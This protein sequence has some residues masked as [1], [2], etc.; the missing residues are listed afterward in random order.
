MLDKDYNGRGIGSAA[1]AFAVD[2]ARDEL[3]LHTDY[4]EIR[5]SIAV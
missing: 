4:D 1:V 2:A 3:G 5:T